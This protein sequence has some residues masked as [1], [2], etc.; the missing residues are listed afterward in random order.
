MSAPD[1]HLRPDQSLLRPSA[2][3]GDDPH[4]V[5]MGIMEH[6][7]ELRRRLL[8]CI[9]CVV[10][11]ATLA[12]LYAAPIF[13]LLTAPFLR[14]FEGKPLIGTAPAEAWILKLKVSV[15]AGTMATAP[16]LFYHLWAFITPGLYRHERRLLL[17]FVVFSTLLFGVGAAF[18]YTVV[19][20]YSFAF[21]YQEFSSIGVTPTIKVGDALS[22]TLTTLLGFGVV[23]EL[24][25]LT[26]FL[27]RGGV[28]DHTFFIAWF[29]HAV[30]G[31]FI[32]AAV[33]TPPDVLTQLLM[34]G[35]LLLLYGLSIG[36]AWCAARSRDGAP[37][38]G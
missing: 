24:P 35:P 28:V 25:L 11:A 12:Y 2:G 17:P 15:F 18:C 22:M 34:A 8:L 6:L 14:A 26:W 36:I 19:L 30:V 20:P 13:E 4:A 21:F 7:R 9:A 1:L 23:F 38:A 32:V 3:S 37:P 33:L 5:Q 31:I 29:R 16:I 10:P 27:A